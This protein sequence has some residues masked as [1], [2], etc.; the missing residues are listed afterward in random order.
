M[1]P[2]AA[3]GSLPA[4]GRHAG[5]LAT[6]AAVAHPEDMAVQRR[7]LEVTVRRKGRPEDSF[8]VEADPRNPASLRDVLRGWLKDNRWDSGRWGEFEL[9]AREADNGSRVRVNVRA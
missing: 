4:P 6:C 3:R 1:R 8:D 2:V 7:T 5:F 9:D